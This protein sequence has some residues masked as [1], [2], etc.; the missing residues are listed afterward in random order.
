MKLYGLQITRALNMLKQQKLWIYQDLLLPGLLKAPEKKLLFF[1]LK[2]KRSGLREGASTSKVISTG[3]LTAAGLTD[4]DFENEVISCPECGS[5]RL[6][7]TAE[8]FG[9]GR[10]CR[11]HGNGS[12]R[13]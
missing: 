3:A 6:V 4:A 11:G 13:F 12:R 7:N 10:C 9:H 5:D 8:S 1:L 2:E